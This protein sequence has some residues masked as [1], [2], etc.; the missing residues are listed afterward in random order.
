MMGVVQAPRWEFD[1]LPPSGARRGGD[2]AE[3]AFTRTLDTFVR[4]ALQNANDQSLHRGNARAEVRFD[5]E[6][7]KGQE[8][9]E[10]RAAIE[11]DAL[12][13]HVRG[14][15]AVKGIGKFRAFADGTGGSG[16]LVLL[17]V[18]DRDTSGLVGGEDESESNF[19]ALCRDSLFSHKESAGAGGSYGLGKSVY[20]SFSA[21][22]TV[23]FYSCL[24]SGEHVGRHRLIGRVELPSHVVGERRFSGPGWFGRCARVANGERAESLW[25]QQAIDLAKRLR[26]A[27]PAAVTGTTILVVGFR[28]PTNEAPE[29]GAE[30][31][32][33]IRASAARFFW[34]A[35]RFPRPL[36][37][38]VGGEP[39]IPSAEV[40]PFVEAWEGRERAGGRLEKPGDVARRSIPVHL[41]R[42]REEK[43]RPD[44]RGQCELVVRL[45]ES[46][47]AGPRDNTV[48]IFRGPGMVV[49]YLPVDPAG[50]RRFHAVLACGEGRSPESATDSDRYV[51]A[52]LRASE[53]PGHDEWHVTPRLKE[54]YIQGGGARLAQLF[55]D[56]R[57]EIREL[58]SPANTD[59]QRGPELLQR[60]YPLGGGGDTAPHSGASPFHFS[61]LEASFREGRWCFSGSVELAT[62]G[63]AWTATVALKMLGDDGVE[64]ERLRIAEFSLH[65]GKRGR[66]E[67]C[68]DGTVI[69]SAGASVDTLK[70]SG[71][72]EALSDP[73]Q[74]CE[75]GLEITGELSTKGGT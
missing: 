4:E 42:R 11:W 32:E 67:R 39:V 2:P 29:G 64:V 65:E 54:E 16:P 3:Y 43:E 20:W 7:L 51:E 6:E 57:R 61:G 66:F 69:L 58:L 41:P 56:V 55:D 40:G 50:A 27:R 19:C 18:E 24:A 23:M 60:R 8:L 59:A 73:N 15:A 25:D 17:R 31:L 53:P 75:L 28:D 5:V 34:P 68:E 37:I 22:S 30:L 62:P 38:V 13:R 12:V 71:V 35:M 9:K 1:A 47:G 14:A 63:R 10:F 45:A 72:S 49:K 21:L 48:A 70:F 52:F 33:R 46:Q 26:I 36:R 44:Q 74:L